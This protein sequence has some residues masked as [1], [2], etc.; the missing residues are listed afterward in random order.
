VKLPYKQLVPLSRE[1]LLWFVIS[2]A[3]LV[4]GLYKGINLIVLLACWMVCLVGLNCWWAR[5][6]LRFV[7]AGRL[8]PD[9]VFG[10]TPFALLIQVNNKGRGTSFGISVHDA[11]ADHQATRFI[12]AIGGQSIVTLSVSM[13]IA[14]RGAYALKPLAISTGFPLALV[15]VTKRLREPN[16]LVVFP[17][18]GQLRRA[19]LR[20]FLGQHSPTLGQARAFP[21][22]HP[23][24]QTEFHGLRPFRSGDSPRW[25]HWR[26]TARRGT[27]MVREFEDMPN[28]H[29]VLIVDP[30]MP[31]NPLLERLLSFAA[32]ICWEW[33]RQKGDRLA[34][35]VTN[36]AA[37]VLVGTT[38]SECAHAML[39]CLALTEAGVSG[40]STLFPDALHAAELP[41]G[42]VLLLSSTP[43][44][45]AN[46]IAQ[47]LH[48]SVAEINLGRE[49]DRD[50]FEGEP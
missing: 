32:T 28:D 48:R 5:R 20:R 36:R 34:L 21:R 41:P 23:G 43:S 44:N 6:Q 42:P 35:A 33:C 30:G 4:T 18:L 24:A 50:F 25:I 46:D 47:K 10:A 26:T 14:R 31:N 8:I 27:L 37:G 16:Q 22:R 15:H 9:F 11:G 1:G 3:M 38:G 13:E 29:L 19:G 39:E 12:A 40:D 45:M 2:L 7:T 17:R 49:E